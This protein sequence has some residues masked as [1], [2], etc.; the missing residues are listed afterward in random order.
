MLPQGVDQCLGFLKDSGI[1]LRFSEINQIYRITEIMF[2]FS[3]TG[4]GSLKTL[5]FA[6][7]S[8]R[9]FGVVPE[10]G[11]ASLVI[12]LIQPNNRAIPVKDA[13]SAGP[14]PA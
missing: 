11:V 4:S 8:L 5:T 1:I 7:Q 10:R 14:A 13:S 2:Q 3:E 9:M 6:H 12:Q